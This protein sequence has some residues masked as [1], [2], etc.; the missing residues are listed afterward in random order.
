MNDLDGQLL[1]ENSFSAISQGGFLAVDESADGRSGAREAGFVLPDG[2]QALALDAEVANDGSWESTA[3]E[4]PTLKTELSGFTVEAE[5]E[6]TDGLSGTLSDQRMT[7][8]GTVTV[9]ITDPT[10]GEFSFEITATSETSGNLTGE[11]N[12]AEEPF[13]ATVVDN[14]FTIDEQSGGPLIDST[15]GL[16]ADEP[17]TNWFELEIELTD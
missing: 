6:F 11:S 2:E 17:G 15:L 14:E 10:E 4:F 12:F 7:A 5:L 9:A 8:T 3:I 13:R 1:F 16:P